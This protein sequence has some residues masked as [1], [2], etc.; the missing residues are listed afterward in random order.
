MPAESDYEK[1]KPELFKNGFIEVENKGVFPGSG[2][3][4]TKD[5]RGGKILIIDRYTD[6]TA[7]F[8][9]HGENTF[10]T[11][12]IQYGSTPLFYKNFDG[13][14]GSNL[15]DIIKRSV[16][17]IVDYYTSKELYPKETEF[18]Y[19]F[20]EVIDAG[21][22]L[23]DIQYGYAFKF[24]PSEDLHVMKDIN[25]TFRCR[26][27]FKTKFD[28]SI[29]GYRP[30]DLAIGSNCQ[31]KVD[32]LFDEFKTE[33]LF[34]SKRINDVDK[35]FIDPKYDTDYY[36]DFQRGIVYLDCYVEIILR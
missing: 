28:I 1:I 10:I 21:F 24:K 26:I 36:T 3:F 31:K 12:L 2:N 27:E 9:I 7:Y 16:D 4:F 15:M 32:S 30:G 8:V 11:R 35:F 23:G 18:E 14:K 22:E 5:Y 17:K 19:I 33:A 34:C 29:A 13:T 25:E 6:Y 20:T